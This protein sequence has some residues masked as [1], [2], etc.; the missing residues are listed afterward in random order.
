[1]MQIKDNAK[2]I[3][4]ENETLPVG[5]Q[6]IV[7]K[8]I[9]KQTDKRYQSALEFKDDILNILE[10][11]E[12][13]LPD[14]GEYYSA[15]SILFE[16]KNIVNRNAFKP[17]RTGKKILLTI[18]SVITA[19]ILVLAFYTITNDNFVNSI[20]SS[21]SSSRIS[22]PS[23]EG[24]N[25]EQ[26]QQIC[27]ELGFDV[28]VKEETDDKN[29]QPGT[30][31]LQTPSANEKAKKG[32]VI[33]VT[34]NKSE[35][36][37]LDN[38][39]G[40]N[41]K[42]VQNFL[43]N[44]GFTVNAIFEESK[45]DEDIVLRQSPSPGSKPKKNSVITLYVSAGIAQNENYVTVPTLTGNTYAKAL[46]LLS[47]CDLTVSTVDGATTPHDDDVVIYQAIP[48]GSLVIKQSGVGITLQ[49]SHTDDSENRDNTANQ[50]QNDKKT[51]DN[52]TVSNITGETDNAN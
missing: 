38:F 13:V 37:L 32:T 19:F 31:I 2:P 43:E 4:L 41:Y 49:C 12:Y 39:A 47:G 52:Q 16:E 29:A 22:V 18:L 25:L 1:M 6:Q 36:T 11:S 40:K 48:A 35:N 5:V 14:V 7:L 10:D 45:K 15:D 8:S 27:D 46:S 50:Q 21:F 42:E 20:K 23:L 9:E 28:V 24:K 34:I 30:V 33:E 51:D 44:S 3:I 26:C 17:I